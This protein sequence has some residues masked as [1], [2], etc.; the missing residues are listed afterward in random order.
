MKPKK[1]LFILSTISALVLASASHAELITNWSLTAPDGRG[2][3]QNGSEATASPVIG[4]G[5][6]DNNAGGSNLYA[7]FGGPTGYILSE[8]GDVITLTGSVSFVGNVTNSISGAFRFGLFDVNSREDLEGWLGYFTQSHNGNTTAKIYERRNPN[9]T[10]YAS[11]TSPDSNIGETLTGVAPGTAWT[12]TGVSAFS[13]SLELLSD[14]NVRATSQLLHNGIDFSE[15]TGTFLASVNGSSLTFNRV[16]F[17]VTNSLSA[18]QAS[19][20]NI[21]VT[22]TAIP[23]PG[24]YALLAGLGAIGLA[25]GVRRKRSRA[26]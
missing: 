14:N 24:T 6:T 11:T 22:F 3:F 9:T 20:S 17:L 2:A 8:V 21:D 10:A 7:S 16:G 1:N 23:E 12:A 26:S 25:A 18:D 19:F 13:L 4:D 5:T 15:A